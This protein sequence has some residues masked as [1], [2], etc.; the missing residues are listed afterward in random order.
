MRIG[1]TNRGTS[2]PQS[3]VLS[4]A[5][6]PAIFPDRRIVV[7]TGQIFLAESPLSELK[8][9]ELGTAVE[10][11]RQVG[12]ERKKITGYYDGLGFY[13]SGAEQDGEA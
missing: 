7:Q 4:K 10:S 13:R 6:L 2:E 8:W 1:T 3:I 12:I 11:K 9:L 5:P